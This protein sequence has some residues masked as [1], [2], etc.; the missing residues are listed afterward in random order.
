MY[1]KTNIFTFCNSLVLCN[2]LGAICKLGIYYIHIN[3][4]NFF[5]LGPDFSEFKKILEI[6]KKYYNAEYREKLIFEFDNEK[7][8]VKQNKFLTL[9]DEYNEMRKYTQDRLKYD[10]DFLADKIKVLNI[11]N[12]DKLVFFNGALLQAYNMDINFSIEMWN[13]YF[14]FG[15]HAIIIIYNPN[16]NTF[17][18][19]DPDEDDAEIDKNI[20]DI[21]MNALCRRLGYKPI[22]RR[23]EGEK[24]QGILDDN[25]CT[26]HCLDIMR[27]I[28]LKPEI[29]EKNDEEIC[30]YLIEDY[31]DEEDNIDRK[32]V[33][34]T[35][36][37]LYCS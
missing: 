7:T 36:E 5:G 31:L 35:Y 9:I 32:K 26:I 20:Y 30:D 18:L 37:K 24:I 13:D 10:M 17:Y 27:K 16:T 29:L 22:Y 8:H 19:I 3:A 23:I 2:V 12:Q 11:N 25:Y 28:S 1:P 21:I 4:R 33:Y 6:S 15:G 34:D 14:S